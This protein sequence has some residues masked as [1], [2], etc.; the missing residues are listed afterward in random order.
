MR[1][2][3]YD[4]K[5]RKLKGGLTKAESDQIDAYFDALEE[6][7]V[8]GEEAET[9]GEGETATPKK[10]LLNLNAVI[11]QKNGVLVPETKGFDGMPD[12]SVKADVEKDAEKD[13]FVVT[14]EAHVGKAVYI[15]TGIYQGSY[16]RGYEKCAE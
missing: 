15:W 10:A 16:D 7:I 13:R 11:D 3:K 6:R 14:V 5:I 9:G 8:N 4:Q 12:P 1:R 2:N